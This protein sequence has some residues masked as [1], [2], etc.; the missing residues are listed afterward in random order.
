MNKVKL[1]IYIYIYTYANT[2]VCIDICMHICMYVYTQIPLYIQMLDRQIWIHV[3]AFSFVYKH[4]GMNL[5]LIV[6]EL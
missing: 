3:S 5:Y 6:F 4:T 2:Y 1:N